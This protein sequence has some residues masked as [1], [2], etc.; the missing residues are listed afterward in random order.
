MA[1]KYRLMTHEE[2]LA[3]FQA[4]V[5]NLNGLRIAKNQLNRSINNSIRAKDLISEHSL[6][7]LYA[8]LYSSWSEVHFSKLVHTPRA[9]DLAD[10]IEVMRVWNSGGGV[11][12]AWLR[13]IDIGLSKVPRSEESDGISD[14]QQKLN[15]IVEEYIIKP[16]TIRNKIAH[17]QWCLPLNTTAS[18]PNPVLLP[19]LGRVNQVEVDNWFSV[20]KKL[21][22]IVEN[23]ITSPRKAFPRDYG[24]ISAKL[25][26]LIKT[27]AKSRTIEIKRKLLLSKVSMGILQ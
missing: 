2:R 12:R 14:A 1:K 25:E 21:G 26:E 13:C 6:S 10:S 3:I 18:K 9:L 5:K 24:Q 23:M 27:A 8:L 4:Q 19:E 20:E 11:G 22:E 17:G 15:E 7:M 16:A